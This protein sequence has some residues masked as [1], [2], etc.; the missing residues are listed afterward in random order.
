MSARLTEWSAEWLTQ[1]LCEWLTSTAAADWNCQGWKSLMQIRRIGLS[2]DLNIDPTV[3][4]EINSE[5][6]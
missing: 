2:I 5:V 3:D 4:A 6:D 1:L